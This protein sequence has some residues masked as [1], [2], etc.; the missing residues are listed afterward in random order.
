[1]TMMMIYIRVVRG[2]NVQ[3]VNE[4]LVENLGENH[5]ENLVENNEMNF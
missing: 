3:D 5:A 4:N 2:A 1:M